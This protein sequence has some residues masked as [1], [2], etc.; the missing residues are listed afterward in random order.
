MRVF[1]GLRSVLVGQCAMVMSC[2]TMFSGEV[3]AGVS[4][5]VRGF[6]VMMSGG[7]MM[8]RCVVMVFNRRIGC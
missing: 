8:G 6:T 3:V 5:L 2:R 7:L 1:V 4:V